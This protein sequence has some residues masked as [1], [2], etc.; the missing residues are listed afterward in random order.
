MYHSIIGDLCYTRLVLQVKMC[1]VFIFGF[2]HIFQ[3]PS[4]YNVRM[5]F[6]SVIEVNFY[7]DN[8]VDSQIFSL[9]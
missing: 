1:M 7:S 5:D 2:K 3:A 8:G 9:L 4:S 6:C